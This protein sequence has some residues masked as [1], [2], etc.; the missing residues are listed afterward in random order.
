MR[1]VAAA[2]ILFAGAATAV[3]VYLHPASAQAFASAS[4]A[5][6]DAASVVISQHLGLEFADPLLDDNHLFVNEVVGAKSFVG[7]GQEDSLLLT[8]NEDDARGGFELLLCRPQRLS[9]LTQLIAQMSS[10]RR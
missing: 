1:T 9:L 10:R 2:C 4:G 6:P 8:I 5:T 3:D 7:Q